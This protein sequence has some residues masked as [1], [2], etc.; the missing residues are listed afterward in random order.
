MRFT[1]K[2]VFRHGRLEQMSRDFNEHSFLVRF[3][4]DG[5]FFFTNLLHFENADDLSERLNE[6]EV[7]RKVFLGAH[8]LDDG[9]FWLHWL[10]APGRFQLVPMTQEKAVETALQKLVPWGCAALAGVVLGLALV[11]GGGSGGAA[12]LGALLF[13]GGIIC[14]VTAYE[15]AA[16]LLNNA[17]AID[18]IMR[19][20]LERLDAALAEG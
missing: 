19:E 3:K 1:K 6:L 14:G 7:G 4:V 2:P 9:G 15:G 16:V 20:G 18:T 8:R 12:V 10:K 17:T 11:V 13:A 5:E